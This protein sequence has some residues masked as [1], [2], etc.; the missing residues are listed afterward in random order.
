MWPF[1]TPPS[2]PLLQAKPNAGAPGFSGRL[3]GVLS[4]AVPRGRPHSTED[5]ADLEEGRVPASAFVGGGETLEQ[6]QVKGTESSALWPRGPQG[7]A[8]VTSI[9]RS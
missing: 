3:A 8:G 7:N 6:P 9:R 4:P 2:P 1:P 5:D